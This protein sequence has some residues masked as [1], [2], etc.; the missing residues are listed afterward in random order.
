MDTSNWTMRHVIGQEAVES[1]LLTMVNQHKLPHAL[2][3]SGPSGSGKL[4]MALG[5]ARLLLCQT[6]AG[7]QPCGHCNACHMTARWAHPDL[8]FTYP[9]VR[10]KD[11]AHSISDAYVEAWR[12]QLLQNPYFS[13][14][15]W[16]NDMKATDMQAVI[17][18]AESDALQRKQ[19]LKAAMGGNKVSI[20]WMPERMNDEC[21]NKLLKLIEEPPAATHFLLVSEDPQRILPTIRSRT[22]QIEFKPPTTA[23][24]EQALTEQEHCS[25]EQAHY[26]AR[27]AAGNYTEALKALKSDGN[28]ALYFD[29]FVLLMRL[30]YQRNIREIRRWSEQLSGLGR[31]RQKE[32]LACCQHLI[33]ENFVFNFGLEQLNRLTVEEA[34]FSRNFARFINER[35]VIDIM[36]EL[37]TAQR[38]IEQNVNPKFVFFD[39]ALKMIVL[40]IR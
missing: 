36:E 33:R 23:K 27:M 14:A 40:L 10:Y 30:A 32:F 1:R 19:S 6:P 9:V 28:R 4:P 26:I 35:N 16:L 13:M 11:A 38:D 24:I 25:P 2:L 20:I 7:E 8:H 37:S 34:N 22:Q 17:Y 5:L 15:D 12:E 21:A 29:L 39:F 18:T 3:F 31:E